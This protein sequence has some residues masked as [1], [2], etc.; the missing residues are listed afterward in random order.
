MAE[1]TPPPLFLVEENRFFRE[2]AKATGSERRD[3]I[4]FF[5]ALGIRAYYDGPT[6]PPPKKIR[7]RQS[8]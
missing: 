2:L 1:G 5:V 4:R 7:R 3:V 6:P 8:K